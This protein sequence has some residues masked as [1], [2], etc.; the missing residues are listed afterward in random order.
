MDGVALCTRFNT[1][2]FALFN[3]LFP[4]L[5]DTFLNNLS[6][7][8]LLLCCTSP[9]NRPSACHR[10]IL[11]RRQSPAEVPPPHRRPVQQRA[12]ACYPAVQKMRGKNG[13]IV[14]TEQ[15]NGGYADAAQLVEEYRT[16]ISRARWPANSPARTKTVASGTFGTTV[17]K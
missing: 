15:M 9:T 7:L 6:H 16:S 11:Q 2:N 12:S 13:I 8:L 10:G 4:H 17:S 14:N 1:P 5:F 3:Y